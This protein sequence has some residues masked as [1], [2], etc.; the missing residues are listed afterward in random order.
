MLT[1]K[2]CPCLYL[3]AWSFLSYFLPLSCWAEGSKEQLGWCLAAIQCQLTSSQILSRS[4]VANPGLQ[5]SWAAPLPA[6]PHC[7]SPCSLDFHLHHLYIFIYFCICCSHLSF[8]SLS[9]VS[10]NVWTQL[11]TTIHFANPTA[12]YPTYPLLLG[13]HGGETWW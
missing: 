1:G 11:T 7:P 6:C 10:H 9:K 13:V 2:W 4:T 3:D 8:W 12:F 5:T